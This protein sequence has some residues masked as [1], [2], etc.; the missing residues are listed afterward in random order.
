MANEIKSVVNAL[1]MQV[2]LN[3]TALPKIY[4]TEGVYQIEGS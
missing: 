3:F 1:L 2:F 4:L